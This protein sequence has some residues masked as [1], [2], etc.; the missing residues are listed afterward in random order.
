M[1]VDEEHN[2]CP[3]CGTKINK[4]TKC[5]NCGMNVE[6]GQ[7]FCPNCGTKINKDQE[8]RHNRPKRTDYLIMVLIL[9]GL[10]VGLWWYLKPISVYRNNYHNALNYIQDGTDSLQKAGSDYLLV[11][12]NSINKIKEE[13][14]NKYTLNSNGEFQDTEDAL[15]M[16]Q[17]DMNYQQLLND[18]DNS[19]EEVKVLFEQLTE[20]P[21]RYKELFNE[22]Q[23]LYSN[24]LELFYM[25]KNPQGEYEDFNSSLTDADQYFDEV[26]NYLRKY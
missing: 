22:L 10:C 2:F 5:S 12:H 9:V 17:Q 1:N 25:I 24:Y 19:R 20:P 21:N 8:K 7:N 16:L 23:I 11:W 13:E 3:N 14:T 15:R 4:N 26:I 18:A 6:E